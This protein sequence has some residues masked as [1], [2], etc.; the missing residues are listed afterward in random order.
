M[1]KIMIPIIAI[2]PNLMNF[3]ASGGGVCLS[4]EALYKIMFGLDLVN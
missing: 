1:A 2:I 3:P 4:V